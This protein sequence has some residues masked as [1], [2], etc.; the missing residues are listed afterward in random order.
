MRCDGDGDQQIAGGMDGGG[1]ALPFQPD[2]LAGDHAGW[3]LDVELLARRQPHPF[4][5]ALD[6]LLQR[7]R[8]GDADVEIDPERALVKGRRAAPRARAAE[9]AFKNILKSRARFKTPAGPAAGAEAERLE[10]ATG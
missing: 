4:L 7:H 6:R 5:A 9:H 10:T 3:N 8:H 1:F 2:L